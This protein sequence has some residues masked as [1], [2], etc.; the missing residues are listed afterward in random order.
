ME[1]GFVD[2]FLLADI[3]INKFFNSIYYLINK[4][5]TYLCLMIK[6]KFI[7]IRFKNLKHYRIYINNKDFNKNDLI[8]IDINKLS[9]SSHIKITA[10]CDN[11]KKEFIKTYKAYN[12]IIKRKG[13]Y[14][15][16]KCSANIDIKKTCIEKYGVD[17]VMKVDSV[18]EK[19]Y[20]TNLDKYG[21]ICSA[22]SEEIMKK[23]KKTIFDKFGT[24]NIFECDEVLNKIR[25]TKEDKGLQCSNIQKNDYTVYRDLINK[26][27]R[28]LKNKLFENWD[29]LDYY[30]NEYIED[31]LKLH[32]S[33]KLYPTIDHKISV[34]YGF[35][36]NIN[37]H[38]IASINNLCITKRS[39][40]SKKKIK[41]HSDFKK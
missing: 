20:N 41:N 13:H 11:C 8:D 34:F 32:Y 19:M 10:I 33:N 3:N 38:I 28:R 18:K 15:C 17:N 31:Y 25:K 4:L 6:E 40:N 29:G 21:H 39:I 1:G 35:K 26:L 24:Y 7:K 30:D 36:N 12:T 22:Q 5:K 16:K 23:S 2:N 9:K 27:T 14:Y 37:P